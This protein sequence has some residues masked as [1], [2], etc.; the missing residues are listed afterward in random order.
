MNLART[1]SFFKAAWCTLAVG[2]LAVPACCG[3]ITL[4]SPQAKVQAE[5]GTDENG[6]LVYTV[7]TRGRTVIEPSKIGV[8]ADGADCGA[9]VTLENGAIR[10]VDET[11]PIL[12]GKRVGKSYANELSQTIFE[13]KSGRR[14]E[15]QARA[16]DDAFAWRIIL[17]HEGAR[18]V[19]GETSAWRLPAG[20]KVWFAERNNAWKLKSYAGEWMAC[21]IDRL[22]TISP[23]GPIQ[24]P[25]LV[26]ELPGGGYA[27]ITEAA[28]YN[29]SGMRL[30]ASGDRTLQVDFTEGSSGF[31]LADTVVTPW[32]VTLVTEDLNALVN[33]DVVA[34]LNPPPER[35]LFPDLAYIRPGRSVWRFLTDHT[36]NPAE[37][38]QYVEYAAELGFEYSLVD[39]GWEKW[40]APWRDL[41]DLVSLGARRNVGILIWKNAGELIEPQGTDKKLRDFLDRAKAA[42]V[43]GVKIDYLNSEAKEWV[44]FEV[45][46]LRLAAD[47]R[48]MIDFHGIWKPT[49]ESRTYPNEIS[50]E[51]IRGLELNYMKEGPITPQHNAALP[52]TRLAVGP[53]DYTPLGYSR[54]GA[55]TW[56]HQLATAVQFTS[57][58]LVIAE[59]PALLLHDEATRP[60]LDVLK[61]IPSVWDETEI[62]PGSSIGDLSLM[63]RRT[64]RTWWLT[65]LN[66]RSSGQEM[67]AGLLRFLPAGRFRGTLITSPTARSFARH[68]LSDLSAATPLH[69]HL[70]AGD[71]FVLRIQ[72]VP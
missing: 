34:A 29:Y 71:G 63:A 21:D 25:P 10:R 64:G 47:R 4:T 18:R 8:V 31:S 69:V 43:K 23:Q 59:S 22:A 30:R 49:G 57:P 5:I 66:G 58:L 12:G 39:E 26:A 41:A 48:L 35:A 28:L 72:P 11:F 70:G 54:P 52:Y 46:A 53:G 15:L 24:T 19:T 67:P 6:H 14:F 13:K 27:L 20:C 2:P 3:A 55:T 36:G 32:R 33:S 42:G 1:A 62:L 51:G 40:P 16:Y 60:A 50:R 68:E 17:R 45:A 44:D 7:A 37:E 38:A 61:E 56:A 9:Q 65:G